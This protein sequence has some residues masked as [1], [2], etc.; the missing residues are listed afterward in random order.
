MVQEDKPVYFTSMSEVWLYDN[1]ICTG[2]GDRMGMIIALSALV[3]LQSTTSV[4]YMEWCTEPERVILSN[5]QFMRWVPGW[6]GFDYPL[7]TVHTAFTLPANIRLFPTGSMPAHI[8]NLVTSNGP[9]PA[10]QGTPQTSTLY[11]KALVMEQAYDWTTQECVKAYRK[12]GGQVQPRNGSEES[13]PYVLVHFRSAD[14]NTH[15]KD[16]LSFCT[17]PVLR[18]LHAAGLFMKVISNNHSVSMQWLRGLPSMQLVHSSSPFKDMAL[19]LSA[20]AIV[21]HASEGWSAYTSVPAMARGIPLINTF[22][23]DGH[24][25]DMF[26]SYGKVP[27]EFYSCRGLREF[28]R[29]VV[30]RT[31][32][33]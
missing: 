24:R 23:G 3:S 13:L 8:D 20:T 26:A 7:E 29:D 32:R 18:E 2:L 17:P 19:A 33:A 10:W 31:R 16:E 11:C 30:E 4:V 14:R 28:V 22:T 5:P 12:A 9:V 15:E 25:F 27:S 21:Q 6:I 1:P